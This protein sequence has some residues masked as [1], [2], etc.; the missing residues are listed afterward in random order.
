MRLVLA[1]E[2]VAADLVDGDD[3]A[4]V[5]EAAGDPVEVLDA[6]VLG[7]EVVVDGLQPLG[8]AVAGERVA[9]EEE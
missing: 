2:L 8:L 9:A 3:V 5:A 4:A 7:G 1:Q 6:G